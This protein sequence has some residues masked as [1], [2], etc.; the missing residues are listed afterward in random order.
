METPVARYNMQ[1]QSHATEEKKCP[2]LAAISI[3]SVPSSRQPK[4][5]KIA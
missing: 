1:P 2:P 4:A 5:V 3:R